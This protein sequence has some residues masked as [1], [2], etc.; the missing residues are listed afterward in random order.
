MFNPWEELQL[1]L[2]ELYF[3]LT[4][5]YQLGPYSI[6]FWDVLIFSVGAGALFWVVSQFLDND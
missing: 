3:W 2:E 4:E 6:S 1:L 5:E